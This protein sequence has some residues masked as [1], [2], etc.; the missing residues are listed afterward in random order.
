MV[1]RDEGRPAERAAAGKAVGAFAAV[2]LERGAGGQQLVG[3]L[4]NLEA[5]VRKQ[6]LVVD[7]HVR[8]KVEGDAPQGAGAGGVARHAVPSAGV[9]DRLI[10]VFLVIVGADHARVVQ[11][12]VEVHHVAGRG[13]LP[14]LIRAGHKDVERVALAA[15]QS[16]DLVEVVGFRDRR[17]GH[18][19][20]GQVFKALD[21]VDHIRRQRVLNEHDVDLLTLELVPG[22]FA[23]TRGGR[24]RGRSGRRARGA[25]SR[26]CR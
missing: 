16:G 6:L 15:E 26:R 19:D 10:E 23:G 21:L 25:R 8:L 7:Q 9:Q 2:I 22:K 24:G 12:F 4:R 14:D 20:A 3:G 11:V 1:S 18:L 5:L 17:V 13:V